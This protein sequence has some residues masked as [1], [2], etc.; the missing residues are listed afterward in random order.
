[1]LKRIL[2]FLIVLFIFLLFIS[3]TINILKGNNFDIYPS[4]NM[5]IKE[6][7]NEKQ[8]N[9]FDFSFSENEESSP[10]DSIEVVNDS[11]IS[12]SAQI[13][14]IT[15]TTNFDEDELILH[16]AGHDDDLTTSTPVDG[17]TLTHDFTDGTE[18]YYT[19]SGLESNTQYTIT[20]AEI[21]GEL[22]DI[23]LTFTTEILNV[24]SIEIIEDSIT[25]SS[26][27]IKVNTSTTNF[28]EDDLILYLES[29]DDN[30]TTSTPVDGIT[31][32]YDSTNE[33]EV[34][35][36]ISG[37]ESNTQYTIT[38]AGINDELT[39]IDL[40]FTTLEAPAEIYNIEVIDSSITN[41]SVQIKVYFSTANIDP[42]NLILHLKGYDENLTTTNSID[43]IE[44]TYDS[45]SIDETEAYYTISGL[46]RGSTYEITE[47]SVDNEKW[48][49]FDD[50]IFELNDSLDWKKISIILTIFEL[51][52]LI[53]FYLLFV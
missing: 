28:D 46:G 16:L 21:N 52:I 8:F 3:F 42:N 12:S 7:D 34:Y 53:A 31:L 45:T 26:V 17:I 51:F 24:Q 50:L 48:I 10:I 22:K 11:I 35:Y 38:S 6:Y 25:D 19:I 39:N 18:I 14:V 30:L 1:M 13:K 49:Q 20:S 23:N 40:S 43:K 32:T 2:L 27:Q 15:S 47:A 29:Y 36:T 37:L 33:T 5:E 44:L 9:N 4:N 41:S